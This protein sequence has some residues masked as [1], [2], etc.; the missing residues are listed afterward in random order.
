MLGIFLDT[1]TNGLNPNKHRTLEIAYQI[2]DLF[3]GICLEKYESIVFQ[4]QEIWNESNLESLKINGFTW[5]EVTKGK[6][7]D[8]REF[9]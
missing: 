3:S 5:A 4:P 2:V 8:E 1:E 7:E 9:R 6:P